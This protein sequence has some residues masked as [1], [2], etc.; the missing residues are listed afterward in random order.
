M[1][2]SAS[3]AQPRLVRA[4]LA[5][6]V[7]LEMLHHADGS[8]TIPPASDEDCEAFVCWWMDLL[9]LDYEPVDRLS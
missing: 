3:A 9:G 6:G 1:L 8:V 2:E 7:R 5:E 4:D